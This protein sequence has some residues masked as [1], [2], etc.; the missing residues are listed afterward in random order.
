MEID[1]LNMI[2]QAI[3]LQNNRN[4]MSEV[5]ELIYLR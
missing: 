1:N 3:G 2:N 4:V 5:E